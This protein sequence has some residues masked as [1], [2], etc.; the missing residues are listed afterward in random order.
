MFFIIDSAMNLVYHCNLVAGQAFSGVQTRTA[1][2]ELSASPN[3][4]LELESG[5]R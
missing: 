2:E 4:W 1:C 3:A 5:G